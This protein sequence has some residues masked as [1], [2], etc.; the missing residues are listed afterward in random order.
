MSS[1]STDAAKKR[2]GEK[3]PGENPVLKRTSDKNAAQ[4]V[5]LLSLLMVLEIEVEDAAV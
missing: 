2:R 5:S 4:D 3:V 1:L